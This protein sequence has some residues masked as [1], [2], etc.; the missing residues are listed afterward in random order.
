[1]FRQTGKENI[2]LI[3]HPRTGSTYLGKLLTANGQLNYIHEPDNERHYFAGY[4]A[5]Q[6]LPRFPILS[7]GDKQARYADLFQYA[8]N[9]AYYSF[10]SMSN[11]I[12][13]KLIGLKPEAVEAQLQRTG[14]NSDHPLTLAYV[15]SYLLPKNIGNKSKRVVKTVHSLLSTDFL[16]P[17]LTNTKIVYITRHPAAAISSMLRMNNA[18]ID[19]QLYKQS[20]LLHRYPELEQVDASW[21]L[22]Q[23]AGVQQAIFNREIEYQAEKYHA[24]IFYFETI[25]QQVF[26]QAHAIYQELNLPWSDRVEEFIIA[27]NQKGSGYETKRE[28][29]KQAYKWQNE[30]DKQQI[31]A[32]RKGYALLQ[33]HH[34]QEF[35]Q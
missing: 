2:F 34:Y 30:L 11:Q 20:K 28:S 7:A 6:A 29:A 31:E 32:I 3:G 18:D 17:Q 10:D 9:Q 8:F 33:P 27:S 16:L 12:L 23:L 26:E 35:Y 13:K 21:P 22:E 15:L 1:M 25:S 5:K 4:Y 19:R 14:V 24:P